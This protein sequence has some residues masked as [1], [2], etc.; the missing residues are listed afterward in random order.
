MNAH[1]IR[2]GVGGGMFYASAPSVRGYAWVLRGADARRWP[3]REHAV[4]IAERVGGRVELESEIRPAPTPRGW[5]PPAPAPVVVPTPTPDATSTSE[6]GHELV[7]SFQPVARPRGLVVSLFESAKDAT[8]ERVGW[9]RETMRETLTTFSVRADVRRRIEQDL[10][11]VDRMAAGYQHVG[12]LADR[13]AELV[14]RYGE[15]ET[16]ATKLREAI[17]RW[18]KAQL[19]AWSPAIYP[20]GL[21]R[22]AAVV[23]GVSCLVLDVDDDTDLDRI[24]S[25]WPE[26]PRVLHTSWS[27]TLER[28]KARLVVPLL[29]PVPAEGWSRVWGW[30][31][32]HAAKAGVKVDLKCSDPSRIYFLPAVPSEDTPRE[33]RTCLEGERLAVRWEELPDPEAARRA[34]NQ[35][36]RP[37]RIVPNGSDRT[38]Y[39]DP[40]VR[41]RIAAELGAG[42]RGVPPRADRL[43]CP[44]CNRPSAYFY[45]E[46]RGAGWARCDHRNSCGWAGPIAELRQEA[47]CPV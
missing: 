18:R 42:V 34:V 14:D 41:T 16:A 32:L 43:L 35:A 27:H 24:W 2:G 45:I 23:V 37:P 13:F 39:T 12:W 38:D 36:A 5:D 44:G 6:D 19:P 17:P 15:R 28:P 3:V 26:H 20:P 1:V 47:P 46:P 9:S 29:E 30:A 8:P 33:A 7:Q 10:R 4:P 21:T 40:V 11:R 31:K 25:L 22:S